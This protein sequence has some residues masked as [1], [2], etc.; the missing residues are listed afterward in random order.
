MHRTSDRLSTRLAGSRSDRQ[1]S[2]E[3][4]PEEPE[5]LVALGAS[6]QSQGLVYADQPPYQW[7]DAWS[8][9][10]LVA[11]MEPIEAEL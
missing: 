3:D 6:P 9:V 5:R 7:N 11:S 1:P 10:S 4:V 2:V 8:T